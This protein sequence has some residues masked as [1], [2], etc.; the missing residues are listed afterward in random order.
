MQSS[1]TK[2]LEGKIAVV[3]GASRGAGRGIAL[4]LG[5][6]GATVYVAARTSRSGPKPA[7]KAPGTIEDTAEQVM[8]RGG[9]G[10]AFRADLGE[11][12]Q[13]AALF[14]R[15]KKDHGHLDILA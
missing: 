5:D 2:S 6:C 4:A 13:V 7:D 9:K 11:G 8:A 3:A 1:G 15:V 14:E 12:D 10:I